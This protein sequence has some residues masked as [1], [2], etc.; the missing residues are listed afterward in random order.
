MHARRH[1]DFDNIDRFE[2]ILRRMIW[3][4]LQ[5]TEVCEPIISYLKIYKHYYRLSSVTRRNETQLDPLLVHWQN[6]GIEALDSWFSCLLQSVSVRAWLV[7]PKHM[8]SN[9]KTQ[10]WYLACSYFLF[11]FQP[12]EGKEVEVDFSYS[13]SHKRLW[14][15]K[16]ASWNF[17]DCFG[18]DP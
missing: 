15:K 12:R 6:D 11:E 2:C 5:A 4:Q 10:D 7:S 1:P 16:G 18:G 13:A 9:H 3:K 14:M 17:W 8:Q